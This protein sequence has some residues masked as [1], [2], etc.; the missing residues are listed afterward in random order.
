MDWVAE[1]LC[2][3]KQNLFV[4]FERLKE[5]IVSLT[6]ATAEN[7]ER[8]T[9]ACSFGQLKQEIVSFTDSVADSA[10]A[11]A[12]QIIEEVQRQHLVQAEARNPEFAQTVYQFDSQPSSSSQLANPSQPS[13]P[14][15]SANP[16]QPSR[17]TQLVYPSQPV[18]PSQSANPSQ[19][20]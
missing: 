9:L 1:R 8:H 5:G 12:S 6:D 14:T 10:I 13:R 2:E 20:S 17:P 18:R 7:I 19:L 3:E 11:R 16:N 4:S 15:Q